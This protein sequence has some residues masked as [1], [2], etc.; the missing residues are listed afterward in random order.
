MK[1]EISDFVRNIYL[2]QSL[3]NALQSLLI[4]ANNNQSKNLAQFQEISNLANEADKILKYFIRENLQANEVKID[5]V[6]ISQNLKEIITV[7]EKLKDE[8][9]SVQELILMTKTCAESFLTE[10]IEEFLLLIKQQYLALDE[11]TL[12]LNDLCQEEE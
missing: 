11:Q 6:K 12:F 8:I 1:K 9:P 7:I 4:I 3:K 5:S 10:K 2:L